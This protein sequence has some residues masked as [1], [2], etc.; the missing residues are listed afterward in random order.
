MND[1]HDEIVR[2]C[3]EQLVVAI[4]SGNSAKVREAAANTANSLVD[5]IND[6]DAEK[7]TRE[8]AVDAVALL[9]EGID[10]LGNRAAER[11]M[12]KERS[13]AR[14][15]ATFNTLT[16]HALTEAD[17]WCFMV[18]LKL[19]RHYANKRGTRDTF[20]DGAAYIALMGETVQKK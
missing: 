17:G 6:N 7:R 11:D 4:Q 19:G 18:V 20:V 15:V 13:M 1:R 5:I 2:A 3:Y 12:E 8:L 14:I 10:T 9:R 16:G